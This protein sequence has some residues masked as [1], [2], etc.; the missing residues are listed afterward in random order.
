M[1]VAT[2]EAENKRL[3]YE[4]A[5]VFMRLVLRLKGKAIVA[6]MRK[7]VKALWYVAQGATFDSRKLF[8]LKALAMAA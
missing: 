7:L 2:L 3:E 5:D 4:D 1:G 8:N 6:I